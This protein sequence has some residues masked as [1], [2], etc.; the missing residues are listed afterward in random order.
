MKPI[1]LITLAITLVAFAACISSPSSAQDEP[2]SNPTEETAHG[3]VNWDPSDFPELG[4]TYV[5]TENAWQDELTDEEFRI[6]REDGTE[7]AFTGD[8]YDH[9][10]HGV[11]TCAGCGAPLYSSEHKF[12]SGTG[13]PSFYQEIEE[14]RVATEMDYAYGMTRTEITCARC[15]GHLGHVFEDGPEPTGLRHCVNSASLDFVPVEE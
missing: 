6:L 1:I 2:T 11:Y 5:L 12:D 7:R 14:G 9:H 10:G 3:A 4:S 8:L 15:G 13:W